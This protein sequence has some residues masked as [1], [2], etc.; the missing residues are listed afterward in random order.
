METKTDSS[1]KPVPTL[2]NVLSLI[3]FKE[4][5]TNVYVIPPAKKLSAYKK[6]VVNLQ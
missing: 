5:A 3:G 6:K 4:L 2:K 1:L